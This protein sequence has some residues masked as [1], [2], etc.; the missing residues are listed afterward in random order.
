MSLVISYYFLSVCIPCGLYN[1]ILNF[2]PPGDI[3]GS[4]LAP[5]EVIKC[6]LRDPGMNDGTSLLSA[7]AAD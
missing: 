3:Q 1:E 6:Q 4:R 2:S 5:W 7:K